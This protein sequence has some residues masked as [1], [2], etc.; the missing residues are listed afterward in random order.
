[1]SPKPNSRDTI[2]PI[3][4]QQTYPLEAFMRASGLGRHSMRAA[5]RLGLRVIRIG[6]RAFVR[7]AD[8]AQ[9]LTTV[10]DQDRPSNLPTELL[11][12]S[13]GAPMQT[14]GAQ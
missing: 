11:A 3:D 12:I 14:G 9:F 2:Q 6:G 5:R 10:A 7:G 4:S 8:F 1:M 13:P